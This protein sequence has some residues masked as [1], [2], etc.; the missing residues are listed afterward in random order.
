ME[1]DAVVDGDSFAEPKYEKKTKEEVLKRIQELRAKMYAL[2][3]SMNRRQRRA[4]EAQARKI[5][6]K[7][8]KARTK[9]K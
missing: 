8:V 9:A 3:P 1:T 2:E 7:K 4:A 5:K 6:K